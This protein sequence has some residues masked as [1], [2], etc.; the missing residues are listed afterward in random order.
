MT[1]CE[2]CNHIFVEVGLIGVTQDLNQKY[3]FGGGSGRSII[4]QASTRVSGPK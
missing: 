3:V 4:L 2:P 1:L